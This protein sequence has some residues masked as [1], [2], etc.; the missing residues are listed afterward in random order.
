MCK[1]LIESEKY[2][3]LDLKEIHLIDNRN[4]KY[5][6]LFHGRIMFPIKNLNGNVVGFSGRLYKEGKPKYI[7]SKTGKP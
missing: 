6:D 5:F 3:P 4:D 7:N 1:A 2:T